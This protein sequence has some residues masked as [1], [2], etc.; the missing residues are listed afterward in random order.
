[1][2]PLFALNATRQDY[3]DEPV[4]LY[5]GAEKL[6]FCEC[7]SGVTKWRLKF[8]SPE[9]VNYTIALEHKGKR[10]KEKDIFLK[11]DKN[12]FIT[13]DISDIMVFTSGL[14]RKNFNLVFYDDTSVI[15]KSFLF[16]IY[17]IRLHPAL[18]FGDPVWESLTLLFKLYADKTAKKLTAKQFLLLLNIIVGLREKYFKKDYNVFY[19]LRKPSDVN[20]E[21]LV[22]TAK[23]SHMPRSIVK[24]DSCTSTFSALYQYLLV[25]KELKD[26]FKVLLSIIGWR[27]GENFMSDKEIF[28]DLVQAIRLFPKECRSKTEIARMEY[29]Q[30][31]AKEISWFGT[32]LKFPLYYL[33][34]VQKYL[35]EE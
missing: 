7:K 15:T 30:A 12:D 27:K 6:V 2:F 14:T 18:L 26:V 11:G 24:W 10:I 8:Y 4:M 31:F 23:N 22:I 9:D 28:E 25:E 17:S 13:I 3:L 33:K 19:L 21:N 5:D 29:K 34:T 20:V 1:M 35:V 16:Q 32:L